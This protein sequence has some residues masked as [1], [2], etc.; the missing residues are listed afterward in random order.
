MISYVTT[1]LR[2]LPL[3]LLIAYF[4]LCVCVLLSLLSDHGIK[5]IGVKGCVRVPKRK[6]KLQ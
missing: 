5:I 3:A 2:M 4:S 1:L 6:I